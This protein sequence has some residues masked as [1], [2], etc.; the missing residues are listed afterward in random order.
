MKR[1]PVHIIFVIIL[2]VV[3]VLPVWNLAF[4]SMPDASSNEHRKLAAFPQFIPAAIDSFPPAYDAWWTDH[5][6]FRNALINT[7]M[8]IDIYAFR[9]SPIPAF[10]IIGKNNWLYNTG[11]EIDVYRGTN[12]FTKDQLKRLQERLLAKKEFIK[13]H[14]ATMIFVIAPLKYSVYPE[15]LPLNLNRIN[16]ESRTDQFVKAL[17]DAGI[18]YVDL[19]KVLIQAKND[20]MPLFY[21]GDNHWNHQGAF[22]AYQAVL[23]KIREYFSGTGAPLTNADYKITAH[24]TSRGNLSDML[25][26][27][28]GCGDYKYHYQR[29]SVNKTVTDTHNVYTPP[30]Y[31]RI[32][33][34]YEERYSNSDPQSPKILII[35]DSFGDH[36]TWFL[37]EHFRETVSIFDAWE[38]KLNPEII[39]REKPDIVMYIVLESFLDTQLNEKGQ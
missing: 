38:Y 22:I 11:H 14:K 23:S 32:K 1:R 30:K 12:R 37:K 18:I 8:L 17:E 15:Y 26:M 13:S 20:T 19:R 25:F 28:E 9:Q 2:S 24:Y 3:F 39:I 33:E 4:K 34:D 10:V 31:F 27:K 7:R 6:P 5:F 21:K 36:I 16:R 35:R 29:I